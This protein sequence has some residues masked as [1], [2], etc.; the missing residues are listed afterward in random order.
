MAY[1]KFVLRLLKSK[2]ESAR[3][4]DWLV[5]S[6]Q[7]IRA[8]KLPTQTL[9]KPSPN[10]IKVARSR[11][12]GDTQL[13]TISGNY[14]GRSMWE[15]FIYNRNLNCFSWNQEQRCRHLMV[16]STLPKVTPEASQVH[17][18]WLIFKTSN[19][20]L[21]RSHGFNDR[22]HW[23]QFSGTSGYWPVACTQWPR[24]ALASS[25]IRSA[26]C[27]VI[28]GG[29]MATRAAIDVMYGFVTHCYVVLTEKMKQIIFCFFL[30]GGCDF[31][32]IFC[33]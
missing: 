22:W 32:V 4:F 8:P 9:I 16:W 30:C 20:F 29:H 13:P 28:A 1:C 23:P 11:W 3:C 7:P 14:W 25:R 24:R 2:R 5:H 33:N 21:I 26:V 17:S 27:C 10:L 15:I 12:T 18:N 19:L 6:S 31:K